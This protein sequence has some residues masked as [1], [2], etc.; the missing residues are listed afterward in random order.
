MR[1]KMQL[2]AYTCVALCRKSDVFDLPRY[3][4]PYVTIATI[5]RMFVK[6]S[7]KYLSSLLQVSL[8]ILCATIISIGAILKKWQRCPWIY[9]SPL[10]SLNHLS[11]LILEVVGEPQITLQQYLSTLPCLPLPSGNLQT[12]FP[13]IPWCYLPISSSVFLSFLLLS[14]PSH[15]AELSSPCQRIL[16]CGHT[17]WVSVYTWV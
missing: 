10:V 14:L 3:R 1:L 15:S 11:P 2:L 16:R 12:P 6:I 4:H 8:P 9:W 17:I 7:L 13:S 5:T